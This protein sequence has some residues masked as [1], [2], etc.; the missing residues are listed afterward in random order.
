MLPEERDDRIQQVRATPNHIAVQILAMVVVTTIR[1]DLTDTEELTDFVKTG[2][3][4]LALRHR[5]LVSH[6]ETGSVAA[7]ARPAWLPNETDREAPFSVYETNHPTTKLDQ[8]FLLIFRTRHVVTIVNVLSDGIR[9]SAR[10]TG[11]PAYSQMRTAPLLVRGAAIKPPGITSPFRPR[12]LRTVIVTAAV[13]RGLDSKLR[14]KANL[15][16]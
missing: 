5:K 8:S 10:Y 16:S 6:L 14:P 11:F 2:H 7:S 15:S 4:L 3:A 13:Y 12:Y 9:G 1:D